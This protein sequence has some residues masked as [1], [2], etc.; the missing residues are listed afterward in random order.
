MVAHVHIMTL[1]NVTALL[2]VVAGLHHVRKFIWVVVEGQVE[3]EVLHHYPAQ[4][5]EEVVV[6]VA[7][8][9]FL[10]LLLKIKRYHYPDVTHQDPAR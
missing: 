3:A 2:R 6:E 5:E 4:M 8:I 10:V 1:I 7:V 9:L